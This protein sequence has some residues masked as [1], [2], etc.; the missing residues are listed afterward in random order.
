M[1]ELV[2]LRGLM[3]RKFPNPKSETLGPNLSEIIRRF[4]DGIS[5]SAS[6]DEHQ[7]DFGLITT[8][9]GTLD[10]ASEHLE[11]N[12]RSLLLDVNSARPRREGR[13][14]TRVLLKSP[15][16]RE[17]FKID[18]FQYVPEMYEKPSGGS[19]M[20]KPAKSTADQKQEQDDDD[21]TEVEKKQAAAN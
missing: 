1:P 16:S 12:L 17:Q 6:K 10:M 19:S 14:I 15:P 20:K 4:S 21:D 18:A 11:E 2:S 7:Q 8:T 3:K 9:I 5:Y 13:F